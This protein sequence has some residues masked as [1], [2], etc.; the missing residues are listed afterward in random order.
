MPIIYNMNPI[1]FSFI[2]EIP[3]HFP[4]FVNTPVDNLGIIVSPLLL[5]YTINK[6]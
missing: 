3:S 2:L 5:R 1:V 6:Y 4:L